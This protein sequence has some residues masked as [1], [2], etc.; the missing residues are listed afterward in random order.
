M[1]FNITSI[2]ENTTKTIETPLTFKAWLSIH[3]G[4]WGFYQV[5]QTDKKHYNVYNKFDNT[6]EYTI[7]K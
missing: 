2:P 3:F 1:K 5:V 7:V 4:A 6:L